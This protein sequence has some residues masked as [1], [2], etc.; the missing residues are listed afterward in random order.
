MLLYI[1]RGVKCRIP[2]ICSRE[3]RSAAR[4]PFICS[5]EYKHEGGKVKIATNWE[6]A[7][8]KSYIFPKVVDTDAF[9]IRRV[10][11][12][13][14]QTAL[15][16][17]LALRGDPRV[18][19]VV[20]FGGSTTIRCHEQSDA[21]VVVRLAPGCETLDVKNDVSEKIQ[22]ATGWN[23]DVLWYDQI[24]NEERLLSHVLKGVQIV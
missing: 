13:M 18:T 4:I 21:D 17:N 22:E 11:P 14:Q 19:A 6:D 8:Y 9:D 12:L 7:R 3:Y 24:R 10:H 1:P 16:I 23:A 20:L 2:F 15:N 5:R